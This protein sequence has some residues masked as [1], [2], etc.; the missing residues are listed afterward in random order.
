MTIKYNNLISTDEERNDRNEAMLMIKEPC[1][2]PQERRVEEGKV[3][4]KMSIDVK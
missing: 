1:I 2:Y 4:I 3:T